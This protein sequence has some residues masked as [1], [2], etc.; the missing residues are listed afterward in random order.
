LKTD[1][2]IH[3]NN[4]DGTLNASEI[5]LT[6]SRHGVSTLAITDHEST[7]G[8]DEAARIGKSYG[9][10][11]I[12]GVEFNTLFCQEEIHLLGYYRSIDIDYLQE[13]LIVLRR[14]RTQHTWKMFQKLKQ[15]GFN[16]EWEDVEEAAG[17]KSNIRKTHIFYAIR[18]QMAQP[19]NP[20]YLNRVASWFKPGGIAF[21]PGNGTSFKE[22][23]DFV[24][25]T[26]GLPVLAHP[27]L[28]RNRGLV[29]DLL[30]YK[31]IGIEVYYAYWYDRDSLISDFESI[32]REKA[33]MATGGTDYHGFFTP[34]EPGEIFVPDQCVKDLKNYL[35]IKGVL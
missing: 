29:M 14:E 20:N 30:D 8:V 27:G 5:I 4:S 17:S 22:A 13:K 1:L 23:V 11:V 9:I 21:V 6:A 2:H 16:I 35:E 3:S 18:K 34:A 28:I 32:S 33:I 19:E 10:E 31:K 26:G 12:P 7:E 25:D 15:T 24:F